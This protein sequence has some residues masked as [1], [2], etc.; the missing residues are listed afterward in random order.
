[1]MVKHDTNG[2]SLKL[3]LAVLMPFKLAL[4]IFLTVWLSIITHGL[5]LLFLIVVMVSFVTGTRIK[6]RI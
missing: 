4:D 2:I 6:E 3:L 1:M 5:F